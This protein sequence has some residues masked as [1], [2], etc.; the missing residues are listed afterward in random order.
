MSTP[1]KDSS[2]FHGL[3]LHV[4][5][6]VAP[7]NVAAFLEAFR[8][9]YELVVK[10]PECT[11]FELFHEADDPGHFRIVENWSKSKEW[12]FAEQLSKPYY[13]PYEKIMESLWI[14]PREFRVFERL[15]PEW[16]R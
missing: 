8:P 12:F 6:T 1:S 14:K 11:Y 5:I 13:K 2:S 10:E 3:S 16:T 4:D 9:T 15:A 7:E